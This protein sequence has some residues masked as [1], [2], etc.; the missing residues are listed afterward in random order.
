MYDEIYDDNPLKY[1]NYCATRIKA[2]NDHM[3]DPENVSYTYNRLDKQECKKLDL[4]LK[5]YEILFDGTLG[6]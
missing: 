4:L 2:T 5:K 3:T 6:I 1:T